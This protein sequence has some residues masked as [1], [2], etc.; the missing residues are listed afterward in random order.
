MTDFNFMLK[1]AKEMQEQMKK[2]QE[3]IKNIE[4][5]GKSGGNLVTVI[6]LSG[7]LSAIYCAVIWPSTVAFVAKIISEILLSFNLLNKDKIFNSS[8]PIPS[9]ADKTPPSTW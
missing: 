2:A 4:V 7:Q 3:E 5:E 1:K 9:I 6:F 8:G